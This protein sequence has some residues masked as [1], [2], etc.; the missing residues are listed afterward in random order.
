MSSAIQISEFSME[1]CRELIGNALLGLAIVQ[2]KKLVYANKGLADIIGIDLEDMLALSSEDFMSIIYPADRNRVLGALIDGISSNR[3]PLRQE[4]RIIRKNGD[5]AWTDARA[6][7]IEF[8]GKRAMQVA[9]MDITSR[10]NAE[11]EANAAKEEYGEILSSISDGFLALDDNLSITYLNKAAESMLGR[12][13][14]DVLGCNLFD[15]FPEYK[16]S[17]FEDTYNWA[18]KEKRHISFETYFEKNP[19]KN[20]Y[21]VRVYPRKNGISVYFQVITER[22]VAEDELRQSEEQ[23]R[24]L[25]ETM[26]QGVVYQDA[27]GK[28]ISANPAAERILGLSIDAMNGRTSIDPRWKAIHEDGSDFPG[29]T[30]PSMTA[31]ST[32]KA[33]ENKIMGV[34]NNVDMDYRWININAIP[35]FLPGET[36]PY[37]VYTTFEDIT[38]RKQVEEQLRKTLES[39]GDGFIALDANWRFIYFNASAERI[40]GIHREEVLG[41]SHWEVFPLTLGTNLER[42]YRFAAAGD[43]RDFENFYEPYGRWFRNRCFPR[44]GGGISVYFEDITDDRQMGEALRKSEQKF[45]SIVESSEAGIIL[46]DDDGNIAEWN[47]S[48]EYIT[49]LKR[50][51]VLGKP[52][53][54]IKFQLIP[55][56]QRTQ[57]AFDKLKSFLLRLT[58][59]GRLALKGWLSDQE[60][61]S[62]DGKRKTIHEVIFP[63]KTDKGYNI[64]IIAHD[65]TERMETEKSLRI[66]DEAIES[67]LNAMSLANPS[68]GLFY[69]NESWLKLMGYEREEIAG[70]SLLDFLQDPKDADEIAGQISA[71]GRWEGELVARKKDGSAFDAYFCAN[72]IENAAGKPLCLHGS[73]LDITNRK[74]MEKE[75]REREERFRKIFELSPIGIQLYDAEGF[76]VSANQASKR[77]MSTIEASGHKRYNIFRDLL[78]DVEDQHRLMSGQIVNEGNWIKVKTDK[79]TKNDRDISQ[80]RKGKVYIE[81][82]M[83]SLGGDGGEPEGYLCLQQD[84]T[85]HRLADELMISENERLQI[86]YDI[87]KTRVKTSNMRIED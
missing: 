61:Q 79:A 43:V 46:I 19:Y 9:F 50:E 47:T 34:F 52:A 26:V 30:H 40:L 54:D 27:E 80:D 67:A 12:I 49:G 41:K 75:L 38:E 63:I 33:V 24:L 18:V 73:I 76:L 17:I 22:K 55:E 6:N 68:G 39:I 53:W 84:L 21:D 5:V 11:I 32:G 8:N 15:A 60:I 35:Q 3:L 25:F 1:A 23:F 58:D 37:R 45:R 56:K 10:K 62:V 71:T 65:I 83:T 66:K 86:I 81:N 72:M 7:F 57:E 77:I 78:S 64:G 87:W 31:L 4:F 44:E 29:E 51:A 82:T 13:A 36:K 70:R 28:I 59:K 14:S 16:G 85:E 42:E 48:Q 2:D 74:K 20:W 69:A